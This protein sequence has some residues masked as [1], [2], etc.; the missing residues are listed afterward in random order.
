MD[1]MANLP[2]SAFSAFHDTGTFE[3]DAHAIHEAV[4]RQTSELKR[5]VLHPDP[6]RMRRVQD[7]L[8]EVARAGT[9]LEDPTSKAPYDAALAQQLAPPPPAPEP[10][11]KPRPRARPTP[12]DAAPATDSVPAAPQWQCPSCHTWIGVQHK[13]CPQCGYS[14]KKPSAPGKA[15][16]RHPLSRAT[17][18]TGAQAR[19]FERRLAETEGAPNRA[20]PGR[21]A[22]TLDSLLLQLGCAGII[23]GVAA[24]AALFYSC[25]AS[26]HSSRY[27]DAARAERDASRTL[28]GGIE[29][30]YLGPRV[31]LDLVR[32][33][34]GSFR[35]GSETGDDREAPVHEVTFA[36][37][38]YMGRTEVTQRQW[39]QVMG[40][41]PSRFAG[42][43]TPVTA[44]SWRDCQE[45]VRKLNGLTG[46]KFTLPSEAEWE[47]ACRAGSTTTYSFGE[48]GGGFSGY[49]W[50]DGNSNQRPQQA[51]EKQANP[52]GLFDM[53]GNI[54]EWCE[55]VWHN[56][57]QGA[58][59]DGSAW[60]VGGYQSDRVVRGGSWDDDPRNCRSASRARASSASAYAGVGCRVVLREF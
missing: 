10:E 46:R 3:P 26:N 43:H 44:V 35:M 41:T 21:Y 34:A 30:I 25:R 58:P 20:L 48:Q 47:Y 51:G 18:Q 56:S 32:V 4:L 53:H 22:K 36:R 29:A 7:L 31:T 40:T 23:V 45:F 28:T 8:N 52:W 49:M 33:P 27:W 13:V 16:P 15:G 12:R 1:S 37:A 60:L 9:T 39:K 11:P 42:E 14:G 2:L 50:Y 55:D 6:D 19:V 38:F 54:W 17:R 59:S 5:Y 57:Y 24:I